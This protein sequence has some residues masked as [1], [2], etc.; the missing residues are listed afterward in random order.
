[1]HLLQQSPST[2]TARTAPEPALPVPLCRPP[3]QVS[4]AKALRLCDVL[5]GLGPGVIVDMCDAGLRLSLDV[6]GLSK[7]GY[8]FEAVEA[9]E[10]NV[11]MLRLLGQ[12]ADEWAQRQRRPMRWL[13][14]WL[15]DDGAAAG[16]HKLHILRDF[17]EQVGGGAAQPRAC[18]A[19][20]AAAAGPAHYHAASGLQAH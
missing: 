19:R 11:L 14:A 3:A 9:E 8:D 20:A 4:K 7:L 10:D 12:V 18:T 13:A 17:L 1:M 5:L 6:M 2:H 16:S 15:Y